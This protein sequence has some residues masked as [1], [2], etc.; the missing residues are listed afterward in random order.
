[1]NI[2]TTKTFMHMHIQTECLSLIYHL[3]F[4]LQWK[5]QKTFKI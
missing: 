1:M 4:N 5:K 2:I 3:D